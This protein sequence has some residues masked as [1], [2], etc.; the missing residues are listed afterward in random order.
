MAMDSD[1]MVSMLVPCGTTN[2][3]WQWMPALDTVGLRKSADDSYWPITVN[4]G[5][6]VCVPLKGQTKHPD[7][8]RRPVTTA[9]SLRLPFARSTLAKRQVYA[10]VFL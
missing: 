1:G 5:K 8:T 4:D 2:G 10:C 6:F 3:N 9:L 7:A